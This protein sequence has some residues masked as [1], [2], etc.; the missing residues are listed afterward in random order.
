MTRKSYLTSSLLLSA[1]GLSLW[2]ILTLKP[3]SPHANFNQQNNPDALIESVIETT[4]NKQGTPALKIESPQMIHFPEHDMTKIKTP[5]ITVFRQSPKPWTITSDTAEAFSGI[6]QIVFQNHVVIHHPSDTMNP[7]T[8]MKT[9]SLTVYPDKQIAQTE[10][11]VQWVQPD[12]TIEAVGMIT[13]L[14]EGT[15]KLLSQAKG[16]YAPTS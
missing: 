12:T 1:L 6:Q 15:V 13:N 2:S 3:A 11:A 9:S 5:R 10:D 4:L 16:I 14:A 7:I 8:T